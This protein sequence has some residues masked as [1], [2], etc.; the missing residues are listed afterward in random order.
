MRRRRLL[1]AT[2]ALSTMALMACKKEGAPLP[3]NPKGSVYDDGGPPPPSPANPKGS[4]Y[5]AGLSQAS[6]PPSDTVTASSPPPP[7]PPPPS[8]RATATGPVTP[9]LPANPK[10]SHYDAGLKPKPKS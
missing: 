2:T 5:D 8:A 1:L 9:R 4:M 3:A 10:G 6:P 7:P